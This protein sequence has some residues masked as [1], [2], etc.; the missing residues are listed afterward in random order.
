MENKPNGS[1]SEGLVFADNIKSGG[2]NTSIFEEKSVGVSNTAC[3]GIRFLDNNSNEPYATNSTG[4]VSR[5]GSKTE[6][7]KWIQVLKKQSK[8]L[9]DEIQ[10][11][12]CLTKA[13]TV[14]CKEITENTVIDSYEIDLLISENC[15]SG[16]DKTFIEAK[17]IG[18]MQRTRRLLSLMLFRDYNTLLTF[19]NSLLIQNTHVVVKILK[20]FDNCVR[21][22]YRKPQKCTL[23]HLESRVDMS[24]II[25][26]LLSYDEEWLPFYN[27]VS[28]TE[29]IGPYKEFWRELSSRVRPGESYKNISGIVLKALKASGFHSD[30][31]IMLQE[32]GHTKRNSFMCR[33]GEILCFENSRDI[34]EDSRTLQAPQ[35]RYARSQ[36]ASSYTEQHRSNYKRKDKLVNTCNNYHNAKAVSQKTGNRDEIMNKDNVEEM[37]SAKKL[38]NE[39][40]GDEC[41]GESDRK[42]VLPMSNDDFPISETSAIET[43]LLKVGLHEQAGKEMENDHGCLMPPQQNSFSDDMY[44]VSNNS[45]MDFPIARTYCESSQPQSE[46]FKTGLP[47]EEKDRNSPEMAL[48]KIGIPDYENVHDS[49]FSPCSSMQSDV[50][51]YSTDKEPLDNESVINQELVR[52]ARNQRASSDTEH[53]RSNYKR[54]DKLV[55]TCNNYHNAKAVSQRTGNR[56]EIMNNDNVEEMVSAKKLYNETKGDK[57]LGESDRKEVLPTSND[58]FPIFEP[59]AVQME[60]LKFDLHE[61]AEN[62]LENDH[63]C[64]MPPQQNSFSDD[65]Y[66]VSNNS[67]MDFPIA[68]T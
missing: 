37:V 2:I 28:Q 51:T 36:R 68:R 11:R 42:E 29:H 5:F 21:N 58:D 20:E 46:S 24:L 35:N 66:R 12:E 1:T 8:S 30:I 25:D 18:T 10:Y 9:S 7:E 22:N 23:C 14:L 33:C 53:H 15:I 16:D 4:T 60:L 27:K 55:N 57:C 41:Q 64:L 6:C 43:E 13:L 34:G 17:S 45:S 26:E 31:V 65:M 40:K 49:G 62:E 3:T 44:G 52:Y 59:S 32:D 54:K 56:D 63:G 50:A 39:S 61:Q 48:L 38:Y 19:V 47:E 67:S